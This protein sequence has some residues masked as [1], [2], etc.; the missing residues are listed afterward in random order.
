MKNNTC[1]WT[2]HGSDIYLT[3]CNDTH[4]FTYGGPED[5]HFIYC[6]YCSGE[7]EV[8]TPP[9]TREEI[10]EEKADRWLQERKDMD[11]L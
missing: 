11:E 10:E 9:P 3:E 8:V 7:I 2:H 1:K 5:N 6:P 4:E